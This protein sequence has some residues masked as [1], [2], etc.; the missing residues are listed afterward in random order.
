MR[1]GGI[2]SIYPAPEWLIKKVTSE[3]ALVVYQ[4]QPITVLK[5]QCAFE[6]TYMCNFTF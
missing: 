1:P 4:K 6:E 3:T 2:S 5:S